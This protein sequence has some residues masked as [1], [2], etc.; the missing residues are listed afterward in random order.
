MS[1]TKTAP[2]NVSKDMPYLVG[3]DIGFGQLKWI[4]N[5]TGQP[6]LIP[7]GVQAGARVPEDK[8]F[9]LSSVDHDNLV[10][11]T[12]E[13]TFFV[14]KHALDLPTGG[15]KRTQIRDRAKDEK[16]RVLFHTGIGLSLPHESGKYNVYIVTGLP[17]E[18]MQMSY[19]EHL[20]A[21]LNK[22]FTITF[23][24]SADRYITKEITIVGADI[25]PQPQG[26]ITYTQF[27]FDKSSFLS[28]T[29]RA[30]EIVGVI[31]IGHFTTDYALFRRGSIIEDPSLA[32]SAGAI[33][34]VYSLL[35]T[36][37]T[38]YFNGFGFRVK[39]DDKMLDQA[40]RTGVVKGV[41]GKDY[42][43]ADLLEEAAREVSAE[44]AQEVLDAWGDHTN[45]LESII[46]TGGGAY[47]LAPYLKEEFDKRNTQGFTVV[48][49]PEFSNVTGFYMY[50]AITLA[51]TY[52]EIEVLKQY[53]ND[54]FKGEAV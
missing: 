44:V 43:V 15:S 47:V 3:L 37:L 1:K 25:I 10:V 33:Q 7:S 2:T 48:E 42:E 29:E 18:D 26:A 17:N 39:V 20:E 41:A 54:V 8:H 19:K 13:G 16:S 9:N 31:D 52:G 28:V 53:V 23:H 6:L 32:G 46:L 45:T 36:K 24:L 22:S 49:N 4:S 38:V 11:S 51:D 30:R 34:K 35:K 5:V 40:V 12:E 50:G 27:R 14:G 21:F